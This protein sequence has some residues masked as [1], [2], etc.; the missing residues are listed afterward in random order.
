[1]EYASSRV[2]IDQRLVAIGRVARKA[3]PPVVAASSI[4]TW[5][6]CP[7]KA[8]H[9]TTLFNSGWLSIE[10]L[11][12]N[13]L[14]GLA[15]LWAAEFAKK[16]MIKIIHGRIMHGEKIDVREVVDSAY[17]A[18][19]L[20][21]RGKEFLYELIKSNTLQSLGLIDPTDFEKQLAKYRS[22][23]NLVEYSKREEWP[24]I[25]RQAPQGFYV[26][27]V[28]DRV[29]WGSSGGGLRIVELKTTSKPHLVRQKR[30]SY[31]AALAQL[32]A[33]SWI[34][35]ERWPV[36][37]AVL[38]VLDNSGRVV[39]KE[40]HDPLTLS[41]WFEENVIQIALS[42]ASQQAPQDPSRVPCRSCEYGG[43]FPGKAV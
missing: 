26:I 43:V 21:S 29:E 41:E 5:Y 28:P 9:N 30:R 34:L 35:S 13:E 19:G 25:A 37:E 42:L 15:L 4:G 18:K 22:A 27:G 10:Q 40:K 33:Y 24:L 14:E 23:E 31:R 3:A 12:E 38:V 16:S 36:E 39:L 2:C 8:W 1:V 6:W 7:L 32:A 17:I 20:V 11:K